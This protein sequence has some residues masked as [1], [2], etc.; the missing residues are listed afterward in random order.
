MATPLRSSSF[1]KG[2]SPAQLAGGFGLPVSVTL[3]DQIE[4]SY[5]RRLARLPADSRRLLL[6]VAADP[7]GNAELIWRAA[8]EL[9]IAEEAA[10]AIERTDSSSFGERVV[11][12]HPLVRSAV[13]NTASPQDRRE[14]HRA[15]G[16]ATDRNSDPDRRAWHLAQ[17]TIRPN[18]GVAD[19]AG[20]V[21]GTCAVAWRICRRRRL[22]RSGRSRLT[23]DPERRAVRA[24]RAAQA[25]RLAGALDSASA[26]AA[27]A[28]RGPLNALDQA[29]LDALMGHIAFARNRGNEV[30][31]RLLKAASRLEQVDADLAKETYLDALNAALF[32]GVW[33]RR[34]VHRSSQ[35]LRAPPWLR[36][37]SVRPQDLIA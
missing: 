13:Y 12:H 15:L 6:V 34:P 8:D 35:R 11:F 18:G 25:K 24:L 14:A 4:E 1:P 10:E 16:R 2:L 9:G 33:R 17:A 37:D 27:V 36:I 32:S 3:A 20:G 21:G 31:P 23:S 29:Q 26:L 30:S 5:R 22:S 28:E 19:R 7:T